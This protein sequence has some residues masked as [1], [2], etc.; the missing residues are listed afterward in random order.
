MLDRL[1]CLLTGSCLFLTA[2][3]ATAQN[4]EFPVKKSGIS[5]NMEIQQES[6]ELTSLTFIPPAPLLQPLTD[7]KAQIKPESD[8]QTTNIKL[9]HWITPSLNLFASIGNVS[10]TGTAKLPALSGLTLPEVSIDLDGSVYKVGATALIKK[11]QYIGSLTYTHTTYKADEFDLTSRYWSLTPTLSKITDAG[12]ISLGL[13][14]Q[15]PTEATVIGKTNTP[16]GVVTA[17]LGINNKHTI[18]WVAGYHTQLGQDL[19]LRTSVGLG[20]KQGARL[21]IN[22]RF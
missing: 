14:Y 19:Y 13:L 6:Y 11:E 17:N 4:I 12:I 21:E 8:V 22:K 3:N 20:G 1:T 15:N 18:S 9:D 16:L 2:F 5:M 7:M 10:G